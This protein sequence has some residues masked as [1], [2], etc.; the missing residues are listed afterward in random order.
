MK[1][2]NQ[3]T[4]MIEATEAEYIAMHSAD[5]SS[6]MAVAPIDSEVCVGNCCSTS[7]SKG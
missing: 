5:L 2:S 6:A 4:M 3:N 1:N 7:S